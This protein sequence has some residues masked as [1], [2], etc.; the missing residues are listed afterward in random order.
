MKSEINVKLIMVLLV[1]VGSILLVSNSLHIFSFIFIIPFSIFLLIVPSFAIL[2]YLDNNQI[3]LIHIFILLFPFVVIYNVFYLSNGL[4]TGFQD[5]QN[6]LYY[7]YKLFNIY[8]NINY[9]GVTQISYNYIGMYVYYYL[10]ANVSGQTVNVLG[11]TIPSII[12]VISLL[13][14]FSLISKIHGNKI[15][16]F[17][18]IIFGWSFEVIL[19]SHEFRTQTF[20]FL[21]ILTFLLLTTI[22]AKFEVK[23]K[24]LLLQ[25]LIVL[26]TATVSFTISFYYII[27]IL[28]I[29][30][31]NIILKRRLNISNKNDIL[32]RILLLFF[33]ITIFYL[34]YISKGFNNIVETIIYLVNTTIRGGDISESNIDLF[35]S[36][37]FVYI[38]MLLF[39]LILGFSILYYSYYYLYKQ[40]NLNNSA[41]ISL[42]SLVLLYV[43][44]VIVN[45]TLSPTRILSVAM[46]FCSVSIIFTV[47]NLHYSKKKLNRICGKL[48]SILIFIIIVSSFIK[49]PTYVIGD[50]SPLRTDEPIDA[51]TYWT[52]NTNQIIA[53]DFISNYCFDNRINLF[54]DIITYQLSNNVEINNITIINIYDSIDNINESNIQQNDLLLM[55]ECYM[56]NSYP[57]RGENQIHSIYYNYSIIYSNDNY[58]IMMVA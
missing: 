25:I 7:Y 47:L 19:F 30:I 39:K 54:V 21:M 31:Y 32:N 3:S 11:S 8:G 57:Q 56:G 37:S 43:L 49:L 51:V 6:H 26:F 18:T 34:L 55:Q 38:I 29:I 48:L 1:L 22:S 12:A 23:Q 10:L 44:D 4:S 45:F 52:S 24:T 40:Y 2:K 5:V 28:T 53:A 15:G 13:V 17:S 16:F 42:G 14:F 9:E 50:T 20:G 46:T 27:M 58:K 35:Y 33:I 41:I 36:G